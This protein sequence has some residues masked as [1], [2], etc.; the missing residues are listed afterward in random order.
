MVLGDP[1]AT[2]FEVFYLGNLAPIDPTEGDQ[3]VSQT[4]VNSWL[5]TYGSA[6]NGL[7]SAANI[8]EFA[9][10]STGV[11]GGQNTTSYDLNNNT[12]NETFTIDGVVKTFDAAMVFNA[13]L[14]YPDGTTVTITAVLAQDTNGDVYL[15]PETTNNAD[16]QALMAGPIQSITLTSPIYGSGTSQGWNLLADRFAADFVPCFTRGATITTPRG[17]IAVEN[18]RQGDRVFTRDHGIQEIAWIGG[19]ALTVDDMVKTPSY[20]PVMVRAG[21]L[22]PNMPE[23][24][25]MLSPHHRLLMTGPQNQM[26]FDEF[27]VLVA[28]K[29]LTHLKG[30]DHVVPNKPIEYIHMMFA[31]HEVILS[32][33]AWSESFQPGDYSMK[34]VGAKQR[35]EIV[36]LFPELASLDG[37][38]NYGS[39]RLA[40][41][42]H[43]AKLINSR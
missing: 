17:E 33:G 15:V 12:A 5:G 38:D 19:R 43:E 1:V 13:T 24:D 28:A 23:S 6:G 29:H 39:A 30:I 7:S 2:S 21:A 42:S 27:E 35:A 22:G 18:L 40:L 41:R 37:L 16:Q 32:N 9:I 11:S 36:S 34:G 8:R 4:A 25:L 3:T 20:Q 14:T 26:Y 10:G 31:Q